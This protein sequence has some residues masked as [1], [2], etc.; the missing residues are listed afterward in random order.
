MYILALTKLIGPLSIWPLH[1]S[2]CSQVIN[3]IGGSMSPSHNKGRLPPRLSPSRS[4]GRLPPIWARLKVNVVYPRMGPSQSKG[5]L[6]PVW[7]RLKVKVVYPGM[8]PFQSKGRLPPPPSPNPTVSCLNMWKETQFIL[9]TRT[10][11]HR[12]YKLSWTTPPPTPPPP[13]TFPFLN[14]KGQIHAIFLMF[15]ISRIYNWKI[16]VFLDFPNSRRPLKKIPPS[17]HGRT[18]WSRLGG[19]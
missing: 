3:N 11:L 6:P 15:K 16:T 18:L 13:P 4:K 19:H 1:D 12:A 7:D 8:G 10:Q 14:E 17:S 2:C 5:R 9:M